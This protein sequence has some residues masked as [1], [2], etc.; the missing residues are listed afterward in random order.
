MHSHD[1][2]AQRSLVVVILFRFGQG[3]IPIAASI[4]SAASQSSKQSHLHRKP[5]E[6]HL[7]SGRTNPSDAFVRDL[8]QRKSQGCRRLRVV[9]RI[10]M[11]PISVVSDQPTQRL[12]LI[13]MGST[14]AASDFVAKPFGD[15]ISRK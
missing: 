10:K 9:E 2:N 7:V 4:R 11:T 8:Q 15:G 12:Q 14:V 13:V 3:G 1:A 5:D 6:L